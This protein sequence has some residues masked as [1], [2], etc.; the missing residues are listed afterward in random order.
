MV[1]DARR[2]NYETFIRDV[3]AAGTTAA[4]SAIVGYVTVGAQRRV[5]G[6]KTNFR[7]Y[8]CRWR[9][10]AACPSQQRS[11]QIHR[12]ANWL[13]TR[14]AADDIGGAV[15]SLLADENRWITDQRIEVSGGMFL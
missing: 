1:I 11:Q 6:T 12:F 14:G 15:A 4:V 7:R 5:G 8:Y 10:A 3:M 2:K 13:W 9:L